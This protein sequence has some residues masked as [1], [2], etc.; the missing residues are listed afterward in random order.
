M[1]RK[2]EA[3]SPVSS[4]PEVN[5][6]LAALPTTNTIVFHDAGCPEVAVVCGMNIS[7]VLANATAQVLDTI[8]LREQVYLASILGPPRSLV[9][10]PVCVTY[11]FIV[12]VGVLGNSL[13]CVVIFCYRMTCWCCCWACRSSST[14]CGRTTSSCSGEGGRCFKTFP[15]ET[16]CFGSILNVTALSVERYVAVVIFMLWLLSLLCA[17][18]NTSVHLIK[19]LPSLFGRQFTQSAMCLSEKYNL[20]IIISLDGYLQFVAYILSFLTT[21][22][23]LPLVELCP[24]SAFTLINTRGKEPALYRRMTTV[25]KQTTIVPR[26]LHSFLYNLMSTRFREMF[27]HI[28]C[29]FSQ[30]SRRS[31]LQTTQ[32]NTLTEK[33]PNRTKRTVK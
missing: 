6:F 26:L 27:S 4:V 8:C 2:R 3:F 5:C 11:L 21:C 17:V 32:H 20:S 33:S 16:V 12:V 7:L 19:V 23:Y 28:T 29:Y 24:I 31:P 15:L 13:T 10:L 25:I 30:W 14:R 9:F 22:L 1:F 18:L